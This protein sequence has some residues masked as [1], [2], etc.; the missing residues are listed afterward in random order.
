MSK[1]PV[2]PPGVPPLPDGL[3]LIGRREWVSFPEWDLPPLRAKIDTGAYSSALDVAGYELYEAPDA[4]LMARLRLVL[5]R[6]RPQRVEEVDAP[7][8]R[9][10]TVRNS[11]GLREQRPLVEPLIRLGPVTRRIRLTITN[12]ARMRTRMLLGR[13]A[14]AGAFLVDVRSKD[15][16]RR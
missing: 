10:V 1:A 4:V 16:L 3:L 15:L 9:L 6:R 7:V 14:L 11:S 12:R 8:V 13:Q 2:G 5:S